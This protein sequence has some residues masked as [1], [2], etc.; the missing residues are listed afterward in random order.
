MLLEIFAVRLS[1]GFLSPSC[2]V[3]LALATLPDLGAGPALVAVACALALRTGLQRDSRLEGERRG[4]GPGWIE[5]A[6]DM[7]CAAIAAL[8]AQFL[9]L[10]AACLA[11][12]FSS[13]YLLAAILP[14]RSGGRS[15]E[16][17]VGEQV[18]L[19]SLGLV[20][21]VLARQSPQLAL[22]CCP[23]TIISLRGAS[24]DW[25]RQAVSSAKQ[26]IFEQERNLASEAV[27]LAADQQSLDFRVEAFTM[28]EHLSRKMMSEQQAVEDAL[29]VIASRFHHSS[30]AYL[31]ESEGS[32]TPLFSRAMVHPPPLQCLRECWQRRV[33]VVMAE[34]AVW[35]ISEKRF[36]W[37]HVA[38]GLGARRSTD[39]GLFCGPPGAAGGS[40]PLS[41]IAAGGPGWGS[42]TA[43]TIVGLGRSPAI[44]HRCQRRP[45]P[46]R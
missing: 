20:A 15:R 10:L 42:R 18:G 16:S 31:Q 45:H 39:S 38:G 4:G 22:L 32:F 2:S 12:A 27:R 21:A 41:G 33:A 3:A 46:M 43:P 7:G 23:A 19:I 30:G 6:G 28:V 8:A 14:E 17:L 25:A 5:V 36:L 9:G 1:R 44:P 13:I 29:A 34:D 35:P 26:V 24:L 11:A 37:L 40:G